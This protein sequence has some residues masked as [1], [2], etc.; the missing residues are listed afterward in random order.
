VRSTFRIP[1]LMPI[2]S[3][4]HGHLLRLYALG[5]QKIII[6]SVKTFSFTSLKAFDLEYK[7]L[8]VRPLKVFEY[9]FDYNGYYANITRLLRN[10]HS[11]SVHTGIVTRVTTPSI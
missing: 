1:N 10:Y 9:D 6:L 2:L 3:T 4:K 11:Q 8:F 7:R 5:D